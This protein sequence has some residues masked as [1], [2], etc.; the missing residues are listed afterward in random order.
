[1]RRQFLMPSN[2]AP[3][4]LS[5]SPPWLARSSHT[6]SPE[7]AYH[8]EPDPKTH[9]LGLLLLLLLIGTTGLFLLLGI[10]LGVVL[11]RDGGD[12]VTRVSVF[13]C[14][15]FALCAVWRLGE[16]S[17]CEVRNGE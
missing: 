13:R 9:I 3:R 8:S 1:M 12:G 5:E 16:R 7:R 6:A 17:A 15:C 4:S 2:D 11:L 10:R 14:G